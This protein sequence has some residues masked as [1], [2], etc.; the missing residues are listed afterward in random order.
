MRKRVG[1]LVA[2]KKNLTP[3]QVVSLQSKMPEAAALKVKTSLGKRLKDADKQRRLS[4]FSE[5]S[6]SVRRTAEER[7][8][9]KAGR[10]PPEGSLIQSGNASV[11]G[12]GD[13]GARSGRLASVDV[14]VC[15]SHL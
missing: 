15:H 14:R 6:E 12:A 2:C 3:R 11:F 13:D 7:A 8:Q 10:S 1:W 9:R 5:A 4:R